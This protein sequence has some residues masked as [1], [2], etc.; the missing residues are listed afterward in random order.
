MTAKGFRMFKRLSPGDKVFQV[1]VYIYL[2]IAFLLVI[3]P[4]MYVVSS[5]LS[6]VSAV[7][8]GR[9]TLFPVEFHID[10]YRAV[11]ASQR[12]MRG[13][14]NSV[15]YTLVGTFFT[16]IVLTMVA[17]PLSRKDLFGRGAITG[18][19]AFTMLFSGGMIPSYINIQNLGLIDT[20]WVMVIPGGIGVM[21]M[22]IMRTYFSSN[23]PY[24]LYESAQM[25]G[26]RDIKFL[27]TVV[28]PL[29]GPIFAVLGL[30]NAVGAW[31]SFFHA[32]LYL[33]DQDKYPLQV[34][35]RNI[36]ILNRGDGDM[37]GAVGD[38]RFRAGMGQVIQF[39]VI[40][41]SSAPLLM[42]YPFIQ[43]FFVKGVMIGALKG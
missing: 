43:K 5:S 8:A 2:T 42:I 17:F 38:D 36:L 34:H 23:I 32:L 39:A 29:S 40:V 20:F 12:I 33:V 24:E 6:S 14:R 21:H 22:A 9:V 28:L 15:N 37:Q 16:L 18:F 7:F 4:L 25:D 41:V 10:A 27:L 31:N 35:L 1:V 30:F 26:C 13:F 19:F 11:F 3:G